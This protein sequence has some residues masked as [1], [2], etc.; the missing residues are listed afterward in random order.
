MHEIGAGGHVAKVELGDASR[1]VELRHLA[2]VHTQNAHLGSA[3]KSIK[4][5][6]YAV[7]GGVGLQH[8]SR[9]ATLCIVLF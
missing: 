9:V 7:G 5:E 4:A 3:F 8:E 1:S 2:T 6:G